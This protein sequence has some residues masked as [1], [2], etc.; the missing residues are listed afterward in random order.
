M[1][2]NTSILLGEYFNGFIQNQIKTGRFNSASEVV[3]N[4]LRLYEQEEKKKEALI[5]ALEKGEISGFQE[6]V[7]KSS[8]LN[9]M[10][11]K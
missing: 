7:S 9:E 8:F 6:N 4:A 1:S 2:K 11:A 5:K 3:R 10:K